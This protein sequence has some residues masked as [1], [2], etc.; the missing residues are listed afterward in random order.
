MT[1]YMYLAIGSVIVLS[2][3]VLLGLS[4]YAR[5]LAQEGI[6]LYRRFKRDH[7]I[8]RWLKMI[9]YHYNKEEYQELLREHREKKESGHHS[10]IMRQTPKP[11]R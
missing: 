4:L 2:I 9:Y 6:K 3:L 10:E 11:R 8:R 7:L 1:N 5:F